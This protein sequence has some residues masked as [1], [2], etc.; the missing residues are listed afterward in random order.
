MYPKELKA[1]VSKKYLYSCV[2]CSIIHTSREVGAT[3]GCVD[4]LVDKE[5]VVYMNNGILLSLKR[6]RNSDTCYNM[7]ESGGQ[8]AK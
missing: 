5:N 2:H 7:D 8:Y 1:K 4:G 3:Q 6:G